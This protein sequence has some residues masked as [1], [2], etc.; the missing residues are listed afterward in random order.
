M[1]VQSLDRLSHVSMSTICLHV[2]VSNISGNK[3]TLMTMYSPRP[4]MPFVSVGPFMA[5]KVELF[6]QRYAF[7][8]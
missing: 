7:N 6:A 2:F 1:H 8:S 4:K 5:V 3:S